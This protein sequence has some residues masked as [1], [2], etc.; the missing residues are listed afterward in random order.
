M[1]EGLGFAEAATRGWTITFTV[2][3]VSEVTG[4]GE[5]VTWRNHCDDTVGESK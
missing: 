5:D 1:G 3:V 2:W 4:V